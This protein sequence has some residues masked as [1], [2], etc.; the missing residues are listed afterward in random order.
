METDNILTDQVKICRPQL[1]EL[2]CAVSVAVIS[3][4]CD[5]VCKSVKPYINNMLR[6]KIYRNS[7]FK[8][9]SGNTEILKSRKKEIVHHLVFTGL[10]LD[11]LR[12]CLDVLNKAVCIFTHFEEICLFLSRNT[13]T[14]AVRTFAVYKLT[15]CK[16]GLTGSTVHSLIMSLVNIAL[17]IHFFEDLLNL[18]LVVF[19]C[20]TNE[21]VIG[22]VHQIPDIF[23]LAGYI[24][25]KF[26]RCNACFFCFQLDF[27]AMLICSCLEKYI[28]SFQSFVA[29]NGI[30]QNSLVGISDMRLTGS[31]SDSCCNIILLLFHYKKS[32][33]GIL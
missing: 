3:D 4:S 12:M 31:I 26:L 14:S 33:W 1:T 19:V 30:C 18:F 16:K 2:L 24:I 32:S 13:G 5:I 7:P 11:K 23:D 6:I 9:S 21:F 8:G 20:S 29:C 27:L 25:N 10:R 22:S 15:L 28:I 17:C